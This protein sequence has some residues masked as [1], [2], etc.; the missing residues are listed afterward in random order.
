MTVVIN[1]LTMKKYLPI[2]FFVLIVGGVWYF[3]QSK[4][5]AISQQGVQKQQQ[6]QK[7]ETKKESG[8]TGSLMDVIKK[9][10]PF[11]CYYK[12]DK[13]EGTIYVKTGKAYMEVVNNGKKGN[14]LVIDKCTWIWSEDKRGTKTCYDK[15]YFEQS[16]EE[17]NNNTNIV[18]SSEFLKYQ[19]KCEP[20]VVDDSMFTPPADVNFFD[21]QQ[22]QEQMRQRLGQ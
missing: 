7:Q 9:S 20:T 1:L 4:K 14:M 16:G 22:M 12:T 17:A 2:L 15:N 21:L 13:S 8:F 10:T 3:S 18:G 6:Q 5:G 19:Y 11:K